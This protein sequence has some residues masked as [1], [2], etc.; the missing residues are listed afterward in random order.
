[1]FSRQVCVNCWLDKT[2]E[3]PQWLHSSIVFEAYSKGSLVL[4]PGEV[5][6]LDFLVAVLRCP[7]AFEHSLPFG[8][9]ADFWAKKD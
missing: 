4:C 1:V 2:G 9:N 3:I 6:P 7:F 5:K 8:N